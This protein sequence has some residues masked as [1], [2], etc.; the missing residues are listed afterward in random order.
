MHIIYSP[1]L[2]KVASLALGHCIKVAY[3]EFFDPYCGGGA[4]WRPFRFLSPSWMTSFSV[5]QMRSSKM[6]TGSGGAAIL[7]HNR[8]RKTLPILLVNLPATQS[9]NNDSWIVCIFIEMYC[10]ISDG[11]LSKVAS[12]QPKLILNCQSWKKI[13]VIMSN[14]VVKTE[15][16]FCYFVMS[17][18]GCFTATRHK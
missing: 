7:R 18:Q 15:R 3:G 6:A 13:S 11:L 1:I 2:F 5:P 8:D 12:Q 4:R 17:P 14:F 16:E 9:G 10:W